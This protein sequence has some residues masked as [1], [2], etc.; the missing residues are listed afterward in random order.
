MRTR[1][2][3]SAA[4]PHGLL[5]PRCQRQ[6]PV[7][8]RCPRDAA[9][10]CG[11]QLPCALRY[12]GC[13][14]R[15]LHG[16]VSEGADDDCSQRSATRNDAFDVCQFGA[17]C[18]VSAG[19]PGALIAYAKHWYLV[20]DRREVIQRRAAVHPD[21][22]AR[23]GRER[24]IAPKDRRPVRGRHK[25]QL[26]GLACVV[27]KYRATVSSPNVANPVRTIT[28]HRD[29][30]SPALPVGHDDREGD[31]ATA[32]PSHHLECG[33][34]SWS[35]PG[36]EEHSSYPIH[37]ADRCCPVAR[38]IGSAQVRGIPVHHATVRGRSTDKRARDISPPVPTTVGCRLP[39]SAPATPR[40]P[41]DSGCRRGKARPAPR[42]SIHPTGA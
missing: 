39:E 16:H 9:R 21:M 32:T 3:S 18:V 28:E 4:D 31:D 30:I 7:A 27:S 14:S 38:L 29:K 35:D 17:D 37:E 10:G 26:D 25:S 40:R 41:R 23:P 19:A 34:A 2:E 22:W 24:K 33:R 1:G 20:G 15:S 8:L 11:L 6:F 36:A 13:P 12:Q 42:Y 5:P